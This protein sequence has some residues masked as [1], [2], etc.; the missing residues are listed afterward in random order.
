MKSF[1]SN[2]WVHS[3]DTRLRAHVPHH[4]MQ[5]PRQR[6]LF[7]VSVPCDL[8]WPHPDC[9]YLDSA[10]NVSRCLFL[11]GLTCG[12]APQHLA[13]SL[14]LPACSQDQLWKKYVWSCA[15]LQFEPKSSTRVD[16]EPQPL[17]SQASRPPIARDG[18]S[19]GNKQISTCLHF[20]TLRPL[21]QA[22]PW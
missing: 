19:S 13:Q 3:H 11:M 20:G 12:S 18:V 10:S 14:V 21:P 15:P 16:T 22:A 7:S 6:H 2:R 1:A 4:W 9:G 5:S 17:F 8:L